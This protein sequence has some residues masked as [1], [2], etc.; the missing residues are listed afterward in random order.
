MDCKKIAVI[1]FTE[2]EIAEFKDIVENRDTDLA[3]KALIK[4][5][6]KIKEFIEPH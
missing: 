6:K 2:A 3:L 5:D 4:I 1:K